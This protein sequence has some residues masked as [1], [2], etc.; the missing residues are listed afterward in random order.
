MRYIELIQQ[1]YPIIAGQFFSHWHRD[2]FKCFRAVNGT[3]I[4]VAWLGSSITP[5]HNVNPSVRKYF[6]D[7]ESSE[8]LDY[9]VYFMNLTKANEIGEI[10]W[11][12]EYSPLKS[13][14]NMTD[15][16]PATWMHI[17]ETYLNNASLFQTFYNYHT[18]GCPLEPCTTRDCMRK[19]Y[20]STVHDSENLLKSPNRALQI[21]VDELKYQECYRF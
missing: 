1:Y 4:S 14:A 10:T 9:E 15:M 3:P 2:E 18:V 16:S 6:F 11:E 12:F 5:Y 19:L 8:I 17:A 21:E 20:C 7:D 13:Y